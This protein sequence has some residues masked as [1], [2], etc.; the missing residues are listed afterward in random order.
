[1]QVMKECAATKAQM[2]PQASAPDQPDIAGLLD[3]HAGDALAA[4]TLEAGDSWITDAGDFGPEQSG[5]LGEGV[6]EDTMAIQ[7]ALKSAQ[8]A[9][10]QN[11]ASI[12]MDQGMAGMMDI[13]PTLNDAAQQPQQQQ[14]SR[15]F[16]AGVSAHQTGEL[17]GGA[18]MDGNE[19]GHDDPPPFQLEIPPREEKKV[20]FVPLPFLLIRSD[21]VGFGV[22]RSV[23]AE[24]LS[25]ND[26]T[27]GDTRW[28][29]SLISVEPRG[30]GFWLTPFDLSGLRVVPS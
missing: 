10:D 28:G 6:E 23:V 2:D 25:G 29:E 20:E 9:F 24:K 18:G 8:E 17:S 12:Q 19:N 15:L 5:T 22:G 11:Q 27:T 16:D 26:A 13:D 1:M 30:V 14:E 4:S 7:N 21:G 3:R